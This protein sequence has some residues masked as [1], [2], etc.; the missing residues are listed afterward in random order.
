MAHGRVLWFTGLP[1]SGKSTLTKAIAGRLIGGAVEVLDADEIRPRYWPELAFSREDRNSNVE[2]L[3]H[4]ARML[5]KHGVLVLVAAIS[6]YRITREIARAM[7]S[8]FTEVYV[9]C[10]IRECMRRDV[11]GLYRRFL[12]GEIKGLTG[13]DDPYQEPQNPEIVVE[14]AQ[15]SLEVCVGRVVE[16]IEA[17]RGRA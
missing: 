15:E 3:A 5:E 8:D 12:E 10:P 17:R 2:R 11:K 13:A 7:I 6:P 4:L 9:K 1:C 16:Y 14:T